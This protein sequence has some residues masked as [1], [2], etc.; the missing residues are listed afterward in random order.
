MDGVKFHDLRSL[1]PSTLTGRPSQ[2]MEFIMVSTYR[3][4]IALEQLR[5]KGSELTYLVGGFNLSEKYESQLGWLFP[6]YGKKMVQTTNQLS[7]VIFDD[8]CRS[9]IP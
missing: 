2:I 6:I 3:K 5:T 7:L 8:I 4:S 1:D 9:I